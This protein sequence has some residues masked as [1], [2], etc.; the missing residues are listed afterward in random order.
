[1]KIKILSGTRAAGKSFLPGK[2]YTVD[3][4][5]SEDDAKIFLKMGRAEEV[6]GKAPAD[7]APATGGGSDADNEGGEGSGNV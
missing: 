1:M 7:K 4:D 6:K 5:V 3:K 2:V